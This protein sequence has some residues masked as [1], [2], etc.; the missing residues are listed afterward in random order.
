[1]FLMKRKALVFTTA[2][3]MFMVT[4]V[5]FLIMTKGIWIYYGDFNVQQIPFYMHLHD[6][7]RSGNLLYDWGTD[8]G[9]SVAGCY[10]FYLLGSPF[11]WLSVPFKSEMVPYLIPWINGIKYGVCALSSYCYLKRHTK[12]EAGAFM[13]AMLY[14]FSGF[15]GA[16]L[17]YNHFHDVMAFFPFF[18]IAFEKLMEEKKVIGFALWTA[19]MAILN[20]YFFVGEVVFLIIYFCVR[21]FDPKKLLRAILSGALGVLL[22]LWYLIPAVS[23]T[24]G[25]SRLTDMLIGKDLVAYKEPVM[26]LGIIKNIVLLPDLSGLN[27]MFNESMSRVSGIGGYLPMISISLVIAYFIIYKKKD[28]CVEEELWPKRVI[29]VCMVFA[30]IPGLNAIF[31]AMNSE[32]YAR[33]YFMPILIMSLMSA[34]ILEKI[35]EDK[36]LKLPMLTGNTVV[37]VIIAFFAVCAILPAKTE[38]GELTIIGG[39]KNPEQLVCQL[40]F[41]LVMTACFFGLIFF[42]FPKAQRKRTVAIIVTAGAFFTAAVMMTSGELLVDM[43]RKTNFISQGIKGGDNVELPNE[44]IW[45]RI[46]TEQDVYNYPMMWNRPTITSF[47]STIPSSTIEF[48]EGI[49]VGRKV[50]SKLGITR[51]G[52]RT[53]L[54]G[55]YYLVEK[56]TPIERIGHVEDVEEMTHF[57]LVG[58]TNGFDIYENNYF[59]PMGIV[60][61]EYITE[62]NYENSEASTASLDRALMKYLILDEG[63]A[64]EFDGLLEEATDVGTISINNFARVCDKRRESACDSFAADKNGFTAHIDLEKEN[65]VLFAVPY[66]VGFTAY[67][68][69]ERTPIFKVDYGLCAVRVDSGSHNI[70]FIYDY[71][72]IFKKYIDELI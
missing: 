27:S 35:P 52:A 56:Q 8:L 68:D 64:K 23:T 46:E 45:C 11:F 57:T 4:L 48:Y 37:A 44:D 61:D 21:Y 10:S 24:L 20:Y 32:Y 47:I 3:L 38:E 43:D 50:T 58:E 65:L 42:V 2:F 22:S 41:T 63:M 62:E 6:L 60:F 66:D 14:A 30:L 18:L 69:G 40:I 51:A 59:V 12:T 16:V 34:R 13:G 70:E 19:F 28:L 54:C 15:S 33:W 25:N 36:G 26:L 71:K 31:S 7:I 72:K 5:P 55:R 1:M 9:G 29:I 67:V 39:L 49:G 17:V 53:L